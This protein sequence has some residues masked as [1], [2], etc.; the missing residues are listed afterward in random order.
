MSNHPQ[1]GYLNL[2]DLGSIAAGL[3]IEGYRPTLYLPNNCKWY[4]IVQAIDEPLNGMTFDDVMTKVK[5]NNYPFI[6]QAVGIDIDIFVDQIVS[7]VESIAKHH[8]NVLVNVHQFTGTTILDKVIEAKTGIKTIL[9]KTHFYEHPVIYSEDYPQI[10]ALISISQCAGL[11]AKAGEWILPTEFMEFDV[12]NNIVYTTTRNVDN[13]AEPFINFPFVRGNILM[14]NDLWNPQIKSSIDP[15]DGILLFDTLDTKVYEFVKVSTQIFD[16][17]HNWEHALWAARNS[18]YIRNTKRTLH[19]ALL[20]DVCDHK[21][22]NSIPREVLSGFIQNTLNMYENIDPLIDKVS[23]TYSKKHQEE[24]AD[25]SLVD[26]DL[27]AVRD[28]DRM[29]ALGYEGIRRCIAVTEMRGGKVPEDVIVHCYD[30]LLR[31]I[32][33]NYI[34]TECGKTLA[35]PGH[36]IIVKYVIDNLPKTQL[37]LDLP[38]YL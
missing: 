25:P 20:H 13:C 30:K 19:L 29:A 32:P 7:F 4:N 9:D 2:K 24:L 5:E 3:N 6:E 27:A 8:K 28:G 14:V 21:Y 37:K 33:E 34:S 23:F 15:Q 16:D 1:S 36:N 18:T 38:K 26:P 31:L 12:K 11:G 35:T 10:D 17:S 22:P